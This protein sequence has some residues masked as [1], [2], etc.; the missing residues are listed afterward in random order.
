VFPAIGAFLGQMK[1]MNGLQSTNK[2]M[3][4]TAFF[5]TILWLITAFKA[6][7]FSHFSNSNNWTKHTT[8]TTFVHFTQLNLSDG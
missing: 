7:A 1:I 2:G 6:T 4:N 3:M 8:V 5:A